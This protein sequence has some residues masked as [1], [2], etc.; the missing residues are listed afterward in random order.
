LIPEVE[1][2]R[3]FKLFFAGFIFAMFSVDAID[4]SPVLDWMDI[5]SLRNGSPLRVRKL[6]LKKPLTFLRV[7][8]G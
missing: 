5:M 1:K 4:S 8:V 6:F 3:R 7:Q 2:I